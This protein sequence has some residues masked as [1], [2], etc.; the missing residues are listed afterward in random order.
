MTERRTP[1]VDPE[2]VTIDPGL[3]VEPAWLGE[4]LGDP[5]I[6]VADCRYDDKYENAH[7]AYLGGHVPGAVHVYWPRDLALGSGPVT[8]LLPTAE[9]A[10]AAM[11][12]LGIGNDTTVVAYDAEGG[13]H[14]AR[15][16]LVLAY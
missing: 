4:R 1:E 2:I 12:R 15:L 13:H 3:L 10:A 11:G 7:A 5:S 9:Q 6:L 14:A 8:N 16:W